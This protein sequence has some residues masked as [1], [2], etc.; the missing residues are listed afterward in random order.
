MPT[1]GGAQQGRGTPT[2]PLLLV[3]FL[4]VPLA[5]LPLPYAVGASLACATVALALIDPIWAAYAAILSVPV[6]D[7]VVLP[8]GLSVTQAALLVAVGTLALHTLIDPER[9]LPLGPLFPPLALLMLALF[10]ATV[11]TPY[12]R[13]DAMRETLRWSTVP[14]IYLLTLMALRLG[15]YP[16]NQDRGRFFREGLP[17]LN[18]PQ[19]Y[20][21]GRVEPASMNTSGVCS[22]Q[23][24]ALWR[25]IG[26]RA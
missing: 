21:D 8:G 6:Q 2:A 7:L 19:R 20:S 25:I 24:P 17:S 16:G 1:E 23:A 5:L 9:P 18:P 10:A 13:A 11:F 3:V 26:L 4:A 12:S 14:L 22:P 15:V